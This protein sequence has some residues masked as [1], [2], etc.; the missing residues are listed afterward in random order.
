MLKWVYNIGQDARTKY[1]ETQTLVQMQKESMTMTTEQNKA[2][3]RGFYQAFEA[4]DQASL[5][6]L[7]APDLEA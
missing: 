7:L 2:I 1:E 6:E 3:V 4:N 5:N